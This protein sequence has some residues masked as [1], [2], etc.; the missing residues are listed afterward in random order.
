VSSDSEQQYLGYI[1]KRSTYETLGWILLGT[2]AVLF[3][4]AYLIHVANGWNGEAKGE[5]LVIAGI[6]STAVSPAFFI[7]AAIT[8]RKAR[9]ALKR[10][11]LTSAIMFSNS[12]YTAISLKVDL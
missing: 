5:S 12:Y 9:L 6:T 4:T 1:K 10:E 3:S 8:K 11:Q 2:G 7:L